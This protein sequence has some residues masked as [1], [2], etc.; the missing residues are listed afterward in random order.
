[1]HI[2]YDLNVFEDGV[3]KEWLD[4]VR[5]AVLWHLGRT[6]PALGSAE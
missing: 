2:F 1:M 3:V 4:E 5:G 6:R